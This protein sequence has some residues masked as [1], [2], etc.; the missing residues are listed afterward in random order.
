ME[1][2][3]GKLYMNEKIRKHRTLSFPKDILDEV[4]DV[5]SNQHVIGYRNPTEFIVDATRHYLIE[6]KLHIVSEQKRKD[7]EESMGI[8]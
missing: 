5:I 1:N 8:R 7:Y 4:K 2:I 3:L 6:T